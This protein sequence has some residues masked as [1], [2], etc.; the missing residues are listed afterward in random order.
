[1]IV[2]VPQKGIKQGDRLNINGVVVDI[3]KAHFI[4]DGKGFSDTILSGGKYSASA[5]LLNISYEVGRYS[6]IDELRGVKRIGHLRGETVIDELRGVKRIG[7]L[8]GETV[9]RLL[10]QYFDGDYE[11]F[12]EGE[13]LMWTGGII[14]RKIKG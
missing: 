13:G 9:A 7:H 12:G 1:M 6:L 3:D 14:R 5:T 11:E 2:N 8:R 4:D 10:K